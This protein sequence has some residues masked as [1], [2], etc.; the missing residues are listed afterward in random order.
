MR[1]H[2]ME[3]LNN[4]SI[5]PRH[6]YGR[7]RQAFQAVWPVA[8]Y[9]Y[10]SHQTSLCHCCRTYEV[11]GITT[12]AKGNQHVSGLTKCQDLASEHILVPIIVG[13]CRE[14]RGISSKSEHSVGRSFALKAPNQFSGKI[15]SLDSTSPLSA[16]HHFL[17]GP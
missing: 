7:V 3:F 4:G 17:P 15:L 2:H 5:D 1:H 6:T 10:H 8:C 12:R 16:N 9:C 13:H 14:D 11:L